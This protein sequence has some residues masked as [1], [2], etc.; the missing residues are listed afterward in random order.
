MPSDQCRVIGEG[1]IGDHQRAEVVDATALAT[2]VDDDF[3]DEGGRRHD[4]RGQ[5]LA[6]VL[7]LIVS[8]PSLKMP[9]PPVAVL[10]A[11]V[12]LVIVKLA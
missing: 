5:L 9:P 12:L 8:V 11:M 2:A 7:S 1:R 3:G 4:G 10:P 6:I